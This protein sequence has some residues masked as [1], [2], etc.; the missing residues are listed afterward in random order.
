MGRVKERNQT[1]W[2][3]AG[4]ARTHLSPK[5]TSASPKSHSNHLP[6][7]VHFIASFLCGDQRWE[8]KYK[9]G[10]GARDSILKS[11]TQGG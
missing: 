7:P 8:I 6:A 2:S 11:C 9:A 4:R 3:G 1:S 5:G 10:K